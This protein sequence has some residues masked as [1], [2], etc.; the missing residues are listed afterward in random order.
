MKPCLKSERL[1]V[2]TGESN[3]S[4]DFATIHSM[5]IGSTPHFVQ[6]HRVPQVE[7]T[8]VA[9]TNCSPEMRNLMGTDPT[10]PPP[11]P[12]C[13]NK[14]LNEALTCLEETRKRG[15][16]ELGR[17]GWLKHSIYACHLA[18]GCVQLK[19]NKRLGHDGLEGTM[20]VCGCVCVVPN[21]VNY[22]Q[23]THPS[24]HPPTHPPTH[25]STHPPIT[26][27]PTRCWLTWF[28][29]GSPKRMY[30]LW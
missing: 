12:P 30:I 13:S 11:P 23:N 17:G 18:S 27:P 7:R 1:L 16:G 5:V 4:R 14:Q 6:T 28:I 3:H 29:L 26:H 10:P 9:S 2:Y 8:W 21:S 15:R 20:R 24:T 19:A 25:P 22:S